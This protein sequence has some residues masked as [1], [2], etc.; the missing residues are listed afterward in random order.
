MTQHS[1]KKFPTNKDD[2]RLLYISVPKKMRSLHEEGFKIVIISNQNGVAK[3]KTTEAEVKHRLSAAIAEMGVPVQV[4]AA[5]GE[6]KDRCVCVRV[7]GQVCGALG[8]WR[9]VSGTV[10]FGRAGKTWA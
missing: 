1:G 8:Y 2:W 10:R 5:L 9:A 3:G 4:F 6:D 7:Y